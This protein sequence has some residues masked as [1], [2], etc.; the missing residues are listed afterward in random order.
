MK[1]YL[2]LYEWSELAVTLLTKPVVQDLIV[3]SVSANS[4]S[5]CGIISVLCDESQSA[6]FIYS[7]YD[8]VCDSE[9]GSSAAVAAYSS[10]LCSTFDNLR[11][12]SL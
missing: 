7:V 3:L 4:F 1:R 11:K 2:V 9:A 6:A 12:A 8:P 5:K 10:Y